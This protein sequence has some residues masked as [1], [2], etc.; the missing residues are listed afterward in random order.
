MKEVTNAKEL[1][2]KLREVLDEYCGAVASTMG[3]GGRTV[4]ISQGGLPHVTKDGVTV[5][6]SIHFSD[7]YK[8]DITS[9]IKEAARKTAKEVGDGTTT[10]TVLAKN[11]IEASLLILQSTNLTRKAFLDHLESLVDYLIEYLDDM[12]VNVEM[13]SSLLK[14]IVSI[15]CNGDKEV[16]E[17]IMKATEIAGIDGMINVEQ[18]ETVDS[19]VTGSGGS[20]IESRVHIEEP[21][22]LEKP[23]LV[24]NEGRIERPNQ[25]ISLL[26]YSAAEK[27]L[28]GSPQP[29]IL[30]AKE[31]NEDVVRVC[32]L[33]RIKGI[34][35]VY[36]VEAEGFGET[37]LKILKILASIADAPV[38]STDASTEND[39]KNIQVVDSGKIG[40]AIIRKN[41]TIL[42][43]DYDLK[44]TFNTEIQLLQTKLKQDGLTPGGKSNLERMLSK[45][46]TTATIKV[47]G[48]TVAEATERKDRVDD[49]VRAAAAA[50]TGGVLP[51]GGTAIYTACKM[52]EQKGPDM[53]NIDVLAVLKDVCSAPLK[54]LTANL[55]T[56]FDFEYLD[57]E[58]SVINLTTGEIV[59]AFNEGILDPALVTINAIQNAFSV[60]KT[61]IN[62]NFYILPHGPESNGSSDR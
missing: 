14:S 21:V 23:I 12:K 47:G 1:R 32:S 42:I 44:E 19:I 7:P 56:D 8:E 3:P 45:Y 22:E 41:E 36:L 39:F 6:E 9:L 58:N 15:S 11:F 54:T 31:F 10:S 35:S 2:E 43:P 24:L 46:S 13:D 61:I 27:E 20:H 60:A 62:S 48:V 49:A 33:N 53:V 17:L 29:I 59:N 38:Y 51:G 5:S 28:Q 4:I 26:R 40:K 30:I 25:I 55:G 34:A 37:R 16:T 50:V 18:V 52:V 57:E